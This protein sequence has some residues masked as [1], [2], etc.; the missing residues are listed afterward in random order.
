MRLIEKV[1]GQSEVKQ[2]LN[3]I[4]AAK[5]FADKAKEL[6]T[7]APLYFSGLTGTG[8]SHFAEIFANVLGD[9]GFNFHPFPVQAGWRFFSNLAAKACSVDEE[10]GLASAIPSIFFVDEAHE[11][12]P[13]EEMV[14]LITGTKHERLFERNGTKFFHDPTQHVWIFASNEELDPA[15][16][17]RCMEVPF[18][19]YKRAE[20]IALLRAMSRKAINDEAA[21][22]F[23]GRTKP[24]AG[25]IQNLCNRLNLQLVNKVDIQ[26][27]KLV[28]KHMGLHPLGLVRKDL[29]LMVRM[30]ADSRPTPIDALRAKAGDVKT[31]ATRARLGWLMAL[32]LCEVRKGGYGLTK[33]GSKYL[34]D[35]AGAQAKE[36]AQAK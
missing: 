29:L 11:H 9:A 6:F 5:N 7:F 26:T 22:Y 34:I 27:A 2:Y 10:S 13:I 4:I 33:K 20:K 14:K 36:K 30:G 32:E 17:R 23:E 18:T 35:L 8:K 3:E 1:I 24:M 28:V 31:S 25:D 19:T 12:S 21:E 16:K 15:Q